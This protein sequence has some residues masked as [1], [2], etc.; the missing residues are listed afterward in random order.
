MLCFKVSLSLVMLVGSDTADSVETLPVSEISKPASPNEFPASSC[1]L[2]VCLGI[3][4]AVCL[5]QGVTVL[6][7]P[8]LYVFLQFCS[9]IM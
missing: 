6:L 1:L 9:K 2:V 7:H 3:G 4:C 5:L 8:S